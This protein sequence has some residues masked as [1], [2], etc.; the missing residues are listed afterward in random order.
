MKFALTELR[1]NRCIV[2]IVFRVR[3]I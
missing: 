1:D 3:S 2:L